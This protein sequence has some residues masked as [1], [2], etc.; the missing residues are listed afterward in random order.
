MKL[1][2][3]MNDIFP[4]EIAKLV[5][6]NPKTKS[7][8]Y[9]KVVLRPISFKQGVGYQMELF[10]KTQVF[11]ENCM[12]EDMM[13]RIINLSL[14]FKQMD[15]FTKDETIQVMMKHIDDIRVKR[16]KEEKV[17]LVEPAQHN[18][19]KQYLLPE[20]QIIPPLI[21]QGIF[22]K[23]GKIVASKYDKYKQINRF[24]EMVDDVIRKENIT[25]LH[26]VDFGCGKSYLTFVLYYYL[27]IMKQIETTITGLDLKEDVINDCNA[28][29]RK[30]GYDGLT[31]Q[32]GDIADYQSDK[33]VDMV[34]TLHACDT[35]T[36]LALY[37]AIQWNS[38]MIFSVPC[39]QHELNAKFDTKE[40]SLLGKYG[41]I[42]ERI[43]SLMTD[44]IRGQLLEVCGYDV[45]LLEFIDIMHSPKNILIRA[46][47]RTNRPENKKELLAQLAKVEE[48]FNASLTLHELLR[49]HIEEV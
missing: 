44:A 45:S 40:F 34:I 7:Q 26:I 25:S 29:A 17:R 2:E 9:N 49:K 38:R 15:I 24:I 46:I 5:I 21:D 27:V 43:S 36:D 19:A 23:E 48:E 37:H 47:K 18:R 31:F 8:Q 30:Y 20:G 28:I 41:I 22:T 3:L 12:P 16:R 42:R 35:A 32:L 14:Q 13:E 33:P 4:L 6:S 10:T 39:C 11:H 1:Q